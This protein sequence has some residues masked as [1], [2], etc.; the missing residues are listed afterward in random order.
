MD[1]R[2]F[3]TAAAGTLVGGLL[4]TRA[5]AANP[6]PASNLVYADAKVLAELT[7]VSKAAS[8]CLLAARSCEQ[9]CHEQ[10]AAGNAK[11]FSECL[12]AVGQMI[13]L[14]E[15]VVAL[16][17]QKAKLIGKVLDACIEACTTCEKACRKHEKHFEH[18]MHAECKACMEACIACREACQKLKGMA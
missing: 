1:R 12:Q 5:E 14:C 3:I 2:E 15:A 13:P 10:L 4:G 6:A 17:S 16:A 8:D 18:G 9:H 7:K 11:E